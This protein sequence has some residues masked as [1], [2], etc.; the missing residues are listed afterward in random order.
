MQIDLQPDEIGVIFRP[1]ENTIIFNIV[2]DLSEDMDNDE[3]CEMFILAL[4]MIGA[5]I[6]EPD[7]VRGYGY[8]MYDWWQESNGDFADLP[9]TD[10]P[11]NMNQKP[12]LKVI[13]GGKQDVADDLDRSSKD[14]LLP[15][16]NTNTE[17]N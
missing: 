17:D 9:E 5:V 1:T 7:T 4:G 12:K 11:A 13:Q 3:I 6:H 10:I 15:E 8:S 16:T 2:E 14:H